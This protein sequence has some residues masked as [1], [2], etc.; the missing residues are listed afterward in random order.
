METASI[1]FSTTDVEAEL[2]GDR[3]PVEIPVQ[4]RERA[5]SERHDRGGA[6][7]GG[8]PLDVAPEH[9]EPGEQ[10]MAERNRLSALQVGIAG[11]A[12]VAVPLREVEQGRERLLEQPDG[13][14]RMLGDVEGEVGGD[15]V[16]AGAPRMDLAAERADDLGQPPLDRHVDVLVGFLEGEGA[17]DQ[18]CI[19]R[20]EAIEH[21]VELLGGEDPGAEQ[22]PGVG[23]RL[24]HVVGRQAAIERERGVQPPEDGVGLSF[25]AR[26]EGAV[27][28][29]PVPAACS[30]PPGRCGSCSPEATGKIGNAVARRL[31][32]RGDE[33]VCLVRDRSRA[34]DLLP[35]G[36][37]LAVGDVTDVASVR[38][39]AEGI[40]AAINAMGIFEQWTA[41]PGVFNRVNAEG[42]R[43]VVATAREAGAARV[44]HTSTFDVFDAGPGGT[45]SEARVA[46][47]DKGTSY[48]RSKQLAERLV[49]AEAERG[50]EVVI[51][52][53][54]GI[55]GPGP[56]A[57]VGWD[58]TLS[59][60]IRGRTPVVPT[61]GLTLTWVDDAADAHIAAL[62]RGR[63]GERYIVAGGYASVRD[64]C[65]IA[66]DEAGTGRVPKVLPESAA[67]ALSRITEGIARPHRQAAADASRA[68]R[69]PA[70]AGPGRLDQGARGAWGRTAGLG[71]VGAPDGALD[72]GGGSRV[73]GSCC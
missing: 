69:L 68:A 42:A 67:M 49:L 50:I 10:M 31:N 38:A 28:E 52:N 46:T 47:H 23:A 1:E 18:L 64:I 40:D 26:H 73:S 13:R 48:E 15:L 44:V 5:R 29:R 72:R 21:P 65:A 70:L 4:S 32:E 34:E 25:E 33:V 16:V 3:L 20:V 36:V 60:T 63:P 43:N 57:A 9:P 45:V 12:P 11:K 8:E 35:A 24:T 66:V 58:G 22:R 71:G 17:A 61:G 7:G 27:Y 59:D 39:A 2:G 53:P 51:V 14:S 37:R 19:D 6:A 55:V 41:D 62:D 54:A 56:W 30:Y